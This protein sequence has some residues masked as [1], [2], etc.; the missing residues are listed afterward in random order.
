MSHSS[1][2]PAFF[3]SFREIVNSQLIDTAK[4]VL[5]EMSFVGKD[6]LK[7]LCKQLC[8]CDPYVTPLSQ[9]VLRLGTGVDAL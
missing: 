6:F 5:Q 3:V 9:N 2:D 1:G 4:P 8:D 7:Q